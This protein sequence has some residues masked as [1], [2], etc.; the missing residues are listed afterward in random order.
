MRV[1]ASYA[2]CLHTKISMGNEHGQP[3]NASL[4]EIINALSVSDS[5]TEAVDA[6]AS[7]I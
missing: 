3:K 6:P 7:G 1:Y 2:P 5:Y 4:A